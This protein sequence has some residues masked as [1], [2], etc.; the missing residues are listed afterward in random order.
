MLVKLSKFS[1]WC[2]SIKQQNNS[3]YQKRFCFLTIIRNF[4]ES[5]QLFRKFEKSQE[6]PFYQKDPAIQ[7]FS[8]SIPKTGSSE[9]TKSQMTHK[10]AK[11]R[12]LANH[13]WKMANFQK[14]HYFDLRS[15]WS[16]D[17]MIHFKSALFRWIAQIQLYTIYHIT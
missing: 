3:N 14:I 13:C 8:I 7:W 9:F 11:T 15:T 17:W 12:K 4:S 16:R 6:W 5:S 1:Q 10:I 2:E